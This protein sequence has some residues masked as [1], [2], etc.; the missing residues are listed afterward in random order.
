[1]SLNFIVRFIAVWL[2]ALA[3]LVDYYS[4]RTITIVFW[5]CACFATSLAVALYIHD[6]HS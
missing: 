2:T 6:R 5:T 3:I 4:N 1:M